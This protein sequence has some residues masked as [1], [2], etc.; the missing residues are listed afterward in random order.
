MKVATFGWQEGGER[1]S[2]FYPVVN[3][4]SHGRT[5][6]SKTGLGKEEETS[7]RR[8]FAASRTR[9]GAPSREMCGRFVIPTVVT[10]VDS[11]SRSTLIVVPTISIS[12]IIPYTQ[13]SK[14]QSTL[15]V[16]R[17]NLYSDIKQNSSKPHPRSKIGRTFSTATPDA[18]GGPR[19]PGP[20]KP[21]RTREP[22]RSL[23]L[24]R[25]FPVVHR[26]LQSPPRALPSPA[27]RHSAAQE[28]VDRSVEKPTLPPPPG[29]QF[30]RSLRSF[31]KMTNSSSTC[32]K[33]TVPP[34]P[35]DPQELK[36]HLTFLTLLTHQ[37]TRRTSMSGPYRKPLERDRRESSVRTYH[38]PPR[39]EEY[40]PRGQRTSYEYRRPE[41]SEPHRRGADRHQRRQRPTHH[42]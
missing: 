3:Q 8:C 31:G 2:V 15:L 38:H 24:L 7:G 40:R 12:Y 20:Q 42:F 28:V 14:K 5:V 19:I 22:S 9:E 13:E 35:P 10:L 29:Q 23:N 36:S 17:A 27:S 16:H 34:Y 18:H 37:S 33:T 1:A 21:S 6:L 32:P 39:R 41:G 26:I 11:L 25:V 30:A 4:I